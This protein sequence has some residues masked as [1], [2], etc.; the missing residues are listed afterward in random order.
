MP[1]YKSPSIRDME[2]FTEEL[3]H[4]IDRKLDEVNEAYTKFRKWHD[5]ATRIPEILKDFSEE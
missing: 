3:F 2:R 5:R 1:D 4:Y